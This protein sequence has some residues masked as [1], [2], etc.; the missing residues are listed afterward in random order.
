MNKLQI[1]SFK[2]GGDV[3][4]KEPLITI[5]MPVF[6]GEVSLA[7]AIESFRNQTFSDFELIISDNCSTDRTRDICTYYA[8]LDTRIRYIRQAQNLGASQNFR[9][10]LNQAR[11]KYFTWA[12]ADDVRSLDFIE[13]NVHFLEENHDYVAS[14]SPNRFEGEKNQSGPWIKFDIKGEFE[15]RV[16]KFMNNCWESHAIFYSV[17]RTN[18][19][20][21]C[22]ILG[23][24]FLGFDWAINLFLIQQGQI[25]RTT[26]G[27]LIFGNK[28]MSNSGN[29][30]RMFRNSM[31]SWPLPFYRFSFFALR[32]TAGCELVWRLKLLSHLLNLNLKTSNQQLNAELYSLYLKFLRPRLRRK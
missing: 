20:S 19:I 8:E 30:W 9:A 14:T 10:V 4:I 31:L 29:R 16:M 27:Q 6:N 11:G 1:E 23:E 5:G 3:L 28:G 21:K 26:C 24:S 22:E 2:Y 13:I 12:A 32:I 15:D 7:F 17:M 25:N 18:T